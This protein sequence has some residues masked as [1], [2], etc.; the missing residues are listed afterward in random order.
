MSLFSRWLPVAVLPLLLAGCQGLETSDEPKTLQS[1]HYYLNDITSGYEMD[2]KIDATSVHVVT[3]GRTP[4]ETRPSFY[5]KL[6]DAE[7]MA[8]YA[9]FKGWTK[10]EKFYPTDVS[11]Q[12]TITYGDY[13]VTTTKLDGI[14]K[15]FLQAKGELDHIANSMINAYDMHRAQLAARAATQSATQA[16]TRPATQPSTEGDPPDELP[17]PLPK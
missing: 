12:Y 3:R 2:V 5:D 7:R 11:P 9:A 1:I 16:A 4:A 14:P 6:T 8:L 17:V 15:T 13:P 10:L